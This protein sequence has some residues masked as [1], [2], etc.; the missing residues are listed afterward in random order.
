MPGGKDSLNKAL[1]GLL[2]RVT[3]MEQGAI[4]DN[5]ESE[6]TD[7]ALSANQGRIL[8]EKIGDIDTILDYI[9]GEVI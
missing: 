7:A 2:N 9:N 6:A 4:V 5:L 1:Q 8:N 3:E